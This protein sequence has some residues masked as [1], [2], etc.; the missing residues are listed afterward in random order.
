MIENIK[1]E[2]YEI[3]DEVHW[4]DAETRTDAKTKV[5]FYYHL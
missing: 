2:F 5:R 4:M 3:L 1:N